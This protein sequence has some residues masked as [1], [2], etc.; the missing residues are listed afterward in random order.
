MVITVGLSAL[1][2]LRLR[3]LLLT[4]LSLLFY[5]WG[6]LPHAALIVLLFLGNTRATVI[7][8]S[9]DVDALRAFAPRMGML[10]R[11]QLRYDGPSAD[12]EER[13]DAVVRQFVRGDLEGPL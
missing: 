6:S 7:A 11:G 4:L 9:S 12:M 1:T 10:Y 3:G 2:P 13:G 8:V 5:A